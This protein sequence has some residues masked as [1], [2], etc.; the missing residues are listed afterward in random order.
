MGACP[1]P[2]ETVV[3]RPGGRDI[4]APSSW[5]DPCDVH[6][7]SK[8]YISNIPLYAYFYNAIRFDDDL[9]AAPK[10]CEIDLAHGNQRQ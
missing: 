3:G 2:S 5:G 6:S 1:N 9:V 7:Q 8:E 4:H 10:L